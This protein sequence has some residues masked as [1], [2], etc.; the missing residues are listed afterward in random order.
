MQKKTMSHDRRQISKPSH[1]SSGE[2]IRRTIV[3]VRRAS[4][5]DPLSRVPLPGGINPSA[6]GALETI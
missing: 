4:R 1:T 5:R 2:A 3:E 6:R